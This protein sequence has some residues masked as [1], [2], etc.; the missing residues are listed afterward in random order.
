[1]TKIALCICENK[2]ADQL[3]DD[4]AAD[5]RL[6]FAS[7]LYCLNPK[8]QASI[9]VLWPFSPVCFGPVR[10]PRGQVFSDEEDFSTGNLTRR[11]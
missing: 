10:K 7:Y 3:R 6:C 1:M 8:F 4:H 9:H 5:Q 11:A 2:K